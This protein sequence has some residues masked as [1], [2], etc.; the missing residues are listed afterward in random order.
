MGT[1]Q[2]F[3]WNRGGVAGY[4][5]LGGPVRYMT[6]SGV[7]RLGYSPISVHELHAESARTTSVQVGGPF[8][9]SF[10]TTLAHDEK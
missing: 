5:G 6:T 2:K 9:N 1:P 10:W 3:G 4:I 8:R 7:G